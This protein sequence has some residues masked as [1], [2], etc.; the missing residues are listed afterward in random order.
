MD[1][2]WCGGIVIHAAQVC[3]PL[4]NPSSGRRPTIRLGRSPCRNHIL[5]AGQGKRAACSLCAD[6]EPLTRRW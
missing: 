6:E 2:R 3:E 1:G 4:L 5:I